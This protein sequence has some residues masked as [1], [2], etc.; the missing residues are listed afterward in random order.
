MDIPIA[1]IIAAAAGGIIFFIRSIWR[2]PE[3]TSRLGR[4]IEIPEPNSRPSI[5]QGTVLYTAF[6]EP[7]TINSIFGEDQSPFQMCYWLCSGYDAT[8][9]QGGQVIVK[10]YYPY[11]DSKYVFQKEQDAARGLVHP[12]IVKI[13]GDGR[14]DGCPFSVFENMAGGTLRSW[15]RKRGKLTGSNVLSV[16]RQVA[17]ALD[18]AHSRGIIHTGVQPGNVWLDPGPEGRAALAEFGV[19]QAGLDVA[20]LESPLPEGFYQYSA[21]E[22]YSGPECRADKRTD[23]YCFGVM[24]YELIAGIDPWSLKQDWFG[25]KF[26][27]SNDAPDIRLCRKDVPESLALRLAQ[28]LSRDPDAR[29]RTAAAVLAGVEAEIAGL[30]PAIEQPRLLKKVHGSSPPV[31]RQ[32]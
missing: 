8:D 7:V 32:A 15:L 13:V 29:P 21:P 10:V 9:A 17:E 19:T 4:R 24:C 18:F 3:M 5:C 30:E 14:V 20:D 1:V 2:L 11:P 31:K 16:L 27:L 23:I 26:K 25:I 12:G 6:N 22:Q 28:T